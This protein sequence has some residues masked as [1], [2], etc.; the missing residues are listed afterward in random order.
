MALVAPAI[1][2]E[3]HAGKPV[4]PGLHEDRAGVA[5]PDVYH[6]RDDAKGDVLARHLVL[7]EVRRNTRRL[8]PGR[9]DQVHMHVRCE[10]REDLAI[11]RLLGALLHAVVGRPGEPH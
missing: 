1:E 3:I 10:R 4:F 2:T 5:H 7:V 9:D 8:R 6:R 11:E